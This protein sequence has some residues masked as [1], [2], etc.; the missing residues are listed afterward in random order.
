M[1]STWIQGANNQGNAYQQW[2]ENTSYI[3]VSNHIFLSIGRIDGIYYFRLE[4]SEVA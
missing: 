1:Q 2:G 4:Y 3:K